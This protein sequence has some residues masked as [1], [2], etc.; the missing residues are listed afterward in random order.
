MSTKL[1][2]KKATSPGFQYPENNEKYELYNDHHT[3]MLNSYEL[4]DFKQIRDVSRDV[5]SIE[6]KRD[7]NTGAVQYIVHRAGYDD[8]LT[9]QEGRKLELKDILVLD[10]IHELAAPLVEKNKDAFKVEI[11]L[12]KYFGEVKKTS[13]KGPQRD[14]LIE[15]LE[16]LGGHFISCKRLDKNGEIVEG[17]TP[18]NMFTADYKKRGHIDVYI[19]APY[20][21]YYLQRATTKPRS[22]VIQRMNVKNDAT[23]IEIMRA[24]DTQMG[25]FDPHGV[26]DKGNKFW[27]I[28]V[29]ELLKE[30]TSLKGART[31]IDK[32]QKGLPP[33]DL[34]AEPIKEEERERNSDIHTVMTPFIEALNKCTVDY[35]GTRGLLSWKFVRPGGL[36]LSLKEREQVTYKGKGT[37]TSKLNFKTFLD[38]TIE[39]YPFDPPNMRPRKERQERQENIIKG[40]QIKA[41]KKKKD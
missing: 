20:N 32:L 41:S 25:C 30:I 7:E 26:D 16:K 33:A 3:G 27:R 2:S 38:M 8:I 13:G 5:Q 21:K 39:Y 23:A 6:H 29:K 19:T 18:F 22:K 37:D 24:L 9:Y 28:T 11:S 4:E 35:S 34:S 14:A 40:K 36:A 12:D 17:I 31:S 10:Y 1:K 15:S